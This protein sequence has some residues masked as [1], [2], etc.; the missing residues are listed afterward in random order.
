MNTRE[1]SELADHITSNLLAYGID[2]S[3]GEDFQKL[4]EDLQTLKNKAEV[5]TQPKESAIVGKEMD[6]F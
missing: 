3:T 5:L 1:F 4:L 6:I 2:I